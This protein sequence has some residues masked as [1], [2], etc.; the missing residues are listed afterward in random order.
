MPG[1]FLPYLKDDSICNRK[2]TCP[3]MSLF[4][5]ENCQK[6]RLKYIQMSLQGHFTLRNPSNFRALIKTASRVWLPIQKNAGIFCQKITAVPSWHFD[7]RV[8]L[9]H[10][11]A[12]KS[13]KRKFVRF[14][15]DS[16]LLLSFNE[17]SSLLVS[18]L[19]ASHMS[20]RV[21]Q[22]RHCILHWSAACMSQ[23]ACQPF[24]VMVVSVHSFE[25]FIF[26][27]G[28]QFW[29]L[30]L[31]MLRKQ[32]RMRVPEFCFHSWYTVA[33]QL[34]RCPSLRCTVYHQ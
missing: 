10:L 22:Q 3:L 23:H 18:T 14:E 16:R 5:A 1:C 21:Q 34:R 26:V 30:L 13:G 17:L 28:F 12:F 20:R 2:K 24:K 6:W 11:L 19:L 4:F 29:Q 7:P 15:M 32:V 27:G 25:L 31:F 8:E 9:K 33:R